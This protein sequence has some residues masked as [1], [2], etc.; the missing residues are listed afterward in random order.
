MKAFNSFY[1][2][3]LSVR[4]LNH[5]F[6]MLIPKKEV[7]ESINDY[8]PIS[9]VSRFYKILA[10]VLAR[11]LILCINEVVGDTQFAFIQGK[12]ITDCA[13]I[14][15]EVVEDVR[16]KKKFAVVFKADFQ[17]TYDTIDWDFL[18]LIMGKMGFRCKW[19]KWINTC[20][21]SATISVLVNGS[22]SST[23]R[24]KR[25]LRQGCPLSPFLFNLVGE[26][27][28]M[29][30]TKATQLDLFRGVEVGKNT[31]GNWLIV[32]HIQFAD[33]LIIFSEAKEESIR[34]IKRMLKIFE[35]A[36]GLRL[37]LKKS[38]L[39]DINTEMQKLKGWADI[40]RCS[41]DSLPTTYLGLPLGY[42]RNSK[43]FWRP[44]LENFRQRLEGW[45]G[46]LLSFG[47]RITLLK[48]ICNNLPVYFMSLF[49]MPVEVA[50]TF[51]RMM[52]S[53]LWGNK[54]NRS[55]HWVSWKDVCRPKDHGGLGLVDIRLRN[56]S[57]LNKW[58]W[59]FGSENGSLWRKVVNAKYKLDPSSLGPKPV[60]GRK[61]N[62]IWRDI[63]RPLS[64]GSDA[65]M[66]QIRFEIGEW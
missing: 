50:K 48:S 46:K 10:K 41:V 6:I 16:K 23:F 18:D 43:E 40:I 7:P 34:N 27:L 63:S 1:K 62:W 2:G 39:Y 52:A 31:N 64:Y 56:R 37:N 21:A 25:G 55:I 17:K 22:P 5:S 13:L 44:V 3:K 4:S 54:T 32:S 65:F 53:F 11:K 29:L 30:I 57:L 14:A 20:L 35:L 49:C 51:E 66:S 9:L 33:D 61:V 60:T 47:G 24:I 36:S 28:S 59:S 15:N 38:K 45:K 26:A 8:R 58:F 19:R 12:Q 42:V